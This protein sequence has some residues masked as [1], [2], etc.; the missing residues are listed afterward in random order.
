MDNRSAWWEQRILEPLLTGCHLRS[1]E[2]VD[3][4]QRFSVCFLRTL[5]SQTPNE[6]PSMVLKNQKKCNTCPVHAQYL[7]T[8]LSAVENGL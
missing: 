7:L 6:N 8:I 4:S 1:S 3:L 5:K 2:D